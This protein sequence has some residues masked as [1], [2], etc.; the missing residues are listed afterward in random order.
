ME[1]KTPINYKKI[2][3]ITIYVYTIVMVLSAIIGGISY[4]IIQDQYQQKIK[5]EEET[6]RTIDSLF[7]AAGYTNSMEELNKITNQDEK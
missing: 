6:N 4:K 5:I 2:F 7:N 1:N 3:I